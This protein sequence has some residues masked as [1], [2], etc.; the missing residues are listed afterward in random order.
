[1]TLVFLWIP[2]SLLP[3]PGFVQFRWLRVRS[4]RWGWP[5]PVLLGYPIL[6]SLCAQGSSRQGFFLGHCRT[7][8]VLT[9]FPGCSQRL[10]V[11]K[12][13]HLQLQLP[14]FPSHK[15]REYSR[16]PVP[17]LSGIPN[18][19]GVF[20]DGLCLP[21]WNVVPFPLALPL[22]KS[23]SCLSPVSHPVLGQLRAGSLWIHFLLDPNC[24]LRAEAF[25]IF[26]RTSPSRELR[27]TPT[28]SG[29]VWSTWICNWGENSPAS[30]IP[31]LIPGMLPSESLL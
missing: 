21:V 18:G 14:T 24:L 26:G 30:C 13:P 15:P 10:V 28:A 4:P 22:W 12:R 9:P 1:M 2:L 31:M 25:G 17:A 16:A 20:G 29:R 5:G 19:T 3:V 6:G 27:G 7:L 8:R 11:A 23:P